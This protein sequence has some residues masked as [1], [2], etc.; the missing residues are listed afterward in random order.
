MAAAAASST[1]RVQPQEILRLYRALLKNADTYPLVSRREVVSMEVMATFRKHQDTIFSDEELSYKMALGWERAATIAKF[2]ENMKWFH[3]RDEVTR[4]MMDFSKARDNE[5]RKE[6][7]RCN[8]VGDAHV[9][10]EDVTS[11]KSAMY[12]N[13]PGY[14]EKVEKNPTKHSRDVWR[15]RGAYGSDTG[16]PRQRFFVKRYKS[17]FPQGW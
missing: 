15:C 3:S 10:T 8:R 13:N 12:H 5:R 9:M 1:A 4:E 11:F 16:G 2:A 14:Y 6:S 7:E 17:I